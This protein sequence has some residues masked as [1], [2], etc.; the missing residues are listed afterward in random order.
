[1][2]TDSNSIKN[3]KLCKVGPAKLIIGIADILYL[4]MGSIA[5]SME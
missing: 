5:A 1:M 2:L 4:A 3:N